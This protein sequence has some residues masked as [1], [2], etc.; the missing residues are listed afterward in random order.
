MAGRLE[1]IK[2]YNNMKNIVLICSVFFLNN[3]YA[4]NIVGKWKCVASYSS[5]DNKA[6]N[7]QAAL[8]QSRPCTKNTIF[9]FQSNGKIVR[10]YSGCDEKY[11]TTQNK[12]W[13]DQKWKLD[14]NNLKTSVTNFSVFREY[15]VAFSGNK[16]TWTNKDETIVYQKQ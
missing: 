10:T 11:V 7:M 9:D 6:N 12:F 2:K 4:Q 14:G 5:F 3:T 8:H 1:K 13:K 16:M 15:T